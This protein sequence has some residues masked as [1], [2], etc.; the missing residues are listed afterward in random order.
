MRH[1]I[2]DASALEITEKVVS[3]KRVTKV[4]KGGRHMR[5]SALVV[6]GDG[7][8]HVGAGIGKAIEIPEAIRKGKED[9]IKKLVSVPVDENGTIPHD[10]VGKFGSASVLLKKAPE[11]TGV[12]AGGPA[13]S[14][15]ELAGIKN[16]RTK[17]LGSNNK[18]NVV[19]A[20]INGLAE[21]K[22]PEEVAKLRGKTVEELYK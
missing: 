9:A 10:Y 18:Q 21:L 7:N 6:V 15:I 1:E 16:I 22:T 8:G 5:F 11:G 3:I 2:I 12:I 17:S 14:V 13:R 4:V 19:L 20:T